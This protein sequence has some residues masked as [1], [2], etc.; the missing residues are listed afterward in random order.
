M[1]AVAALNGPS[2]DSR[3]IIAADAGV[4]IIDVKAIDD[5]FETLLVSNSAKRLPYT[6]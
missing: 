1:A 5:E 6:N 2:R 4:H 3:K